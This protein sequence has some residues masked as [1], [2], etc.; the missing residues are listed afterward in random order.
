M[1]H[2]KYRDNRG[3]EHQ[4]GAD[5]T[6]DAESR[7]EA[8]LNAEGPATATAG[9]QGL[10]LLATAAGEDDLGP[11][12]ELESVG[13]ARGS[14]LARSR[15]LP[16]TSGRREEREARRTLT[17]LP[18]DL[19]GE[20]GEGREAQPTYSINSFS[21]ESPRALPVCGYLATRA[22]ASHSSLL[23][24]PPPIPPPAVGAFRPLLCSSGI[25]AAADA[26]V[27][28]SGTPSPWIT[29]APAGRV[30][31]DARQF[32][33][34]K[35][36]AAE[37]YPHQRGPQRIEEALNTIFF[38][39]PDDVFGALAN[40]FS[41]F[42][43]SPIISRIA[44]K[45][46]LD[47]TGQPT[48]Q[49]EIFCT[50]KNNEKSMS[51]IVMSAGSEPTH[52]ALSDTAETNEQKKEQSIETALEWIKEPLNTLLKGI[53]PT[54]QLKTDQLLSEYFEEK[55]EEDLAKQKIEQE[56]KEKEAAEF[57]SLFL[58]AK[59][60]T[61]PKKRKG[62][63]KGKKSISSDIHI[64]P[65]E[66]VES[67][68]KGSIAIG[69]TSLAVAKAGAAVNRTPLYMYIASLK[70]KQQLPQQMTMP[71]PL[72]TLLSSGK[73]TSG[74]LN[75]MK[76]VIGIPSTSLTIQES[77]DMFLAL[78]KE[79]M[80]LMDKF[81]KA[82][83]IVKNISLLG[84][85][86]IG[87]DRL[88]QPLDLIQ[89]A[90]NHLEL[91]LGTNM[92]L[93]INCAAHEIIDYTKGKY[94][95][96]NGSFKSPDEMVDMYLDLIARYPSIIALVDP[97]RKE[98]EEQWSNIYNAIG[99]KCYFIAEAASKSISKLL[100]NQN[101]KIPKASGLVLKHIDRTT[102]SDLLEVFKLVEGENQI[103]IIGSSEEESTDDSLAD[104]AVGLEAQFIKLG[105]LLRGERVVK[106]NRLLVIEE[107]M[108]QA[109]TLGQR[110]ALEFHLVT[111]ATQNSSSNVEMPSKEVE[112]W[113]L[114]Q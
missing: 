94:E 110:H 111:D 99:S 21:P 39:N 62:T 72:V 77:I 29:A 80:V 106:Y 105:G 31:P 45:K 102:I 57:Q 26:G 84:C 37:Y 108:S 65:A 64:L 5:A 42:S 16:G 6:E 18:R 60:V 63:P 13:R 113:D 34:L 56:E 23:T 1:E 81:T 96:L 88:E 11:P 98:D 70:H 27:V 112:D 48:I 19:G 103:A 36:R 61:P 46:V 22:S 38:R 100:E 52:S 10:A 12:E 8:W 49:L 50:V 86:V 97:L 85:L 2:R 76:E 89:E 71:L 47:G 54:E 93:A 15:S 25:E 91:E 33:E 68:L 104:L 28:P 20:G 55:L 79:I 74:K 109:A 53:V 69:A 78:H 58:P 7:C 32:Y 95:V 41:E 66:P 40:W 35:Q 59:P 14:A 3:A 92:H 83:P 17:T 9:L 44:G 75:L 51:S 87:F 82:G 67:I 43:K 4:G 101:T 114:H 90:C 24:P 107:E 73:S 30:S